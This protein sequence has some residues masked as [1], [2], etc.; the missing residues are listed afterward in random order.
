MEEHVPTGSEDLA[1]PSCT[2]HRERWPHGFGSAW[3]VPG[4]TELCENL[5]TSNR[6]PISAIMAG[7]PYLKTSTSFSGLGEIPLGDRIGAP[8]AAEEPR[9]GSK[10]VLPTG[11]SLLLIWDL[12]EE[13]GWFHRKLRR[14]TEKG[15]AVCH[16]PRRKKPRRK[17]ETWNLTASFLVVALYP[18]RARGWSPRPEPWHEVSEGAMIPS[19]ASVV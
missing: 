9:A 11:W 12:A 4:C 19:R 16:L 17:V 1:W 10:D 18:C 3:D 2:D 13:G 7:P 15:R 14:S 6:A 5:F 8:A